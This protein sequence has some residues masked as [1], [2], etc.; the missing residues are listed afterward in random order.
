MSDENVAGWK[1]KGHLY[2]WHYVENTRNYRGWNLTADK[3]FRDSFV[4][5][6]EKI[7]EAKYNSLKSLKI[8]SPTAEI[9]K[10]P[11]NK[12][13][14][15]KW[16]APRTLILKYQKDKI[17]GNY[18]SFDESENTITLLVDRQKLEI[19]KEC[20]LKIRKEID[21]SIEIGNARLWFW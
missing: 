7:S 17:T 14:Q 4:D 11:N 16:K 6:I 2:L 13:G 12:G 15:A 21:Y 9:L 19:L 8:T 1:Q 20:F 18:L 5:L 3:D 10:V